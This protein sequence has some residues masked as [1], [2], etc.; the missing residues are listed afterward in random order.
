MSFADTLAGHLGAGGLGPVQL[1][2]AFVGGLLA[3]FGPC[4]L[5][6]MPAVFGYVTG[7]VGAPGGAPTS[8]PGR[9]R[10]CSWRGSSFWAWRPSSW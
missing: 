6:M 1:L 3:G 2:I 5:P 7:S 4:V 10:G 9:C 8:G